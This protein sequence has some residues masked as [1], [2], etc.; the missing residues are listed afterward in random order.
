MWALLSSR[1]RLWLFVTVGVPLLAWGLG[2]LAEAIERR[3]SN[4][5]SRTLRKG[6]GLLRRRGR[7]ERRQ[8]PDA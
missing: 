8:H 4:Q 7:Q 2:A 6:E 5:V 1:L 3:G